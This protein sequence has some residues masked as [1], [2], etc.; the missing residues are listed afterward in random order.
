[1]NKKRY[2]LFGLFVFII[3]ISLYG[4]PAD[5]DLDFRSDYNENMVINGEMVSTLIGNVVFTYN[6]L[7]IRSDRTRWWRSQGKIKFTGNVEVTQENQ[8]VTC[9]RMIFYKERNMLEAM[10]NFYYENKRDNIVL[11]GKKGVYRIDQDEFTL[12]GNPKMVRYDSTET[13]TLEIVGLKM[14]YNDSLNLATVQDCVSIHKGPLQAYSD[15]AR[16]YTKDYTSRL[17]GTPRIFYDIHSITGDSIDL[18]FSRDTLKG[19]SVYYEAHGRYWDVKADSSDSSLTNIWSDS[20][21]LAIG[22]DGALDSIRAYKNVKSTYYLTADSDSANEV[23]GKR[24]I[25]AF[26]EKGGQINNALVWGNARSTYYVSEDS[27]DEGRNEASGD[28]IKVF[29]EE[30]RATYLMLTG[31][32]RGVYYPMD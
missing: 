8:R 17:R 31:S 19:L 4:Q 23:T 29:F 30:G 21:Y 32:V 13:D 1:M 16:H 22:T 11:T 7:T 14:I 3:T 2:I 12:T 26:S 9:R 27:G 24:M 15:T 25:L 10:G 6:D 28:S 18:H 5:D 20:M